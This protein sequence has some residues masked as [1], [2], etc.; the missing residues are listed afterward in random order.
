MTEHQ[1]QAQQHQTE[2]TIRMIIEE[3][4]GVPFP[5]VRPEWLTNPSTK[6]RLELD[7]YNED[8]KL[9]FEYDGAQHSFYTPHYHKN[10]SHFEYRRLLDQLKTEL[11]HQ[12]GV[13]LVRINWEQVQRDPS[14]S[15]LVALVMQTIT[16]NPN[17]NRHLLSTSTDS[18]NPL[19][20]I[21]PWPSFP[22][23]SA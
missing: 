21:H 2:S 17:A 6:R 7:M 20:S 11:C 5:K 12:K 15:G 22:V 14:H 23:S 16:H 4:Y 10:E 13:T 18:S 19:G 1:Q 8:L 9:A 3:I